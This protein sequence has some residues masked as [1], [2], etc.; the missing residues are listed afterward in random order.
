[1]GNI[2]KPEMFKAFSLPWSSPSK[3]TEQQCLIITWGCLFFSFLSEDR[4]LPRPPVCPPSSRTL[5]PERVLSVLASV[6][7]AC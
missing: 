6:S 1:M 4:D 7:L 2:I 5:K 3:V